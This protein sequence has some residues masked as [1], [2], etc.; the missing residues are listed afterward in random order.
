M[1]VLLLPTNTASD[2]SHKV[3]ALRRIGIDAR[4]LAFGGSLVQSS[5]NIKLI[6]PLRGKSEYIRILTSIKY[7]YSAIN[8]AD[9]LHWFTS[10]D[11]INLSSKKLH[12]DIRKI[13]KKI[14]RKL[15]KPGVIQWSGSDIRNPEIDCRVNRFYKN[16]YRNGY[17][18]ADYE[19][20]ENSLSNQK[21]FAEVGFYPL[22][23]IGME[24]SI[25]RELFPKSFPVWQSVD[26]SDHAPNFPSPENKK[27]LIVHSPTAPVA[28]GTH[29]ILEAVE[30]LKSKYDFNFKLV[31]NIERKKAL[32]IMRDCDIFVDQLILGAHGAA[33]VEAMAFGK[34]VICNI[35]EEIGK[36]YPDD[37]PLINANPETIAEKLEM[38]LKNPQMRNEIGKKSRNYVEKYHDERKI[39]E[40]LVETYQ[41]VIE[42]HKQKNV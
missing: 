19:N 18:Y 14:V 29:F 21:D 26:L 25:D 22:E 4:G 30:K 23:F 28:K 3:K 12:L 24:H 1:K 32:E 35:N 36:N 16:A 39:A 10:F 5:E 38:L 41:T 20:A 7:L 13:D 27:P 42:L 8:R 6:E 31:Q 37:L 33:A 9:I 15:N 2:L 40:S 34:P 17:E 11:S